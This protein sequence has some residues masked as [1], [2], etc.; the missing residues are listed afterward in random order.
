[1]LA[2]EFK[3]FDIKTIKQVLSK[4][5]DLQMNGTINGNALIKKYNT[6]PLH[7]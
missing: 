1:L 2:I 3:D 6:T 7:P 4:K 5:G